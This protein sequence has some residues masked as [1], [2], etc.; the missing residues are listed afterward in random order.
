MKSLE[1]VLL[2]SILAILVSWFT[3]GPDIQKAQSTVNITAPDGFAVTCASS[4]KRFTPHYCFLP[5]V[6]ASA[7]LTLGN[8]CTQLD[9]N[10]L[11][12]VPTSASGVD[13]VLG[14]VITSANAVGIRTISIQFFTAAGCGTNVGLAKTYAVREEVAAVA[15][16]F[17]YQGDAFYTKFPLISGSIW[18]KVN[19][20]ARVSQVAQVVMV[21]YYD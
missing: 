12:L 8:V 14:V 18:Y 13:V 17:L 10:A 20:G 21:G 1:R 11:F 16:T 15:G 6:G 4:Y 5:G 9:F 19:D 2:V 3:L 7:N